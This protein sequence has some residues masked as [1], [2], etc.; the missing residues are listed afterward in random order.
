MN[1]ETKWWPIPMVRS[2]PPFRSGEVC[3]G[4]LGPQV[5]HNLLKFIEAAKDAGVEPPEDVTRLI[6]ELEMADGRSPDMLALLGVCVAMSMEYQKLRPDESESDLEN[7][8][9]DNAVTVMKFIGSVVQQSLEQFGFTQESFTEWVV[10]D[11]SF[12]DGKWPP[13]GAAYTRDTPT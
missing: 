3:Y 1:D 13:P 4:V 6:Q 7:Q 9:R 10:R 2:W 5:T 8:L 11:W 12:S